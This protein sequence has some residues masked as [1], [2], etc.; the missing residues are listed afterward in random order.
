[1]S[2]EPRQFLRH[3]LTETA[4]LIEESHNLDASTVAKAGWKEAVD[5][6]SRGCAYPNRPVEAAGGPWA[7]EILTI[8]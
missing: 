8:D 3:I 4:Y 1:M 6:S 2:V 7:F 5:H